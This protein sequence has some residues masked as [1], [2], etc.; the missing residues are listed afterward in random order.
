M[1]R[2]IKPQCCVLCTVSPARS[3]APIGRRAREQPSFGYCRQNFGFPPLAPGPDVIAYIMTTA[4]G[5]LHTV[6]LSNASIRN[7]ASIPNSRKIERDCIV[8]PKL[9]A[10]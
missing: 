2:K 9:C 10:D 8:T 1:L 4:V 7:I 3:E 6:T 5:A